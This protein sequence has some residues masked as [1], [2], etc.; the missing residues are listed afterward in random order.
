MDWLP[1]DGAG[2]NVVLQH[3]T[4]ISRNGSALGAESAGTN[5]V[6]E[7]PTVADQILNSV[8][9][10]IDGSDLVKGD[11]IAL[12]FSRLGNLAADTYGDNIL[13]IRYGVKVQ[14]EGIG[15]EKAHP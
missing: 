1:A 2:G 5:N 11:N 12:R 13:V 7:C 8:L 4:A 15:Q 3:G 9:D 6:E 10:S 14:L